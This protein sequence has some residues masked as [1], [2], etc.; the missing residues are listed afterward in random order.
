M[1]ITSEHFIDD[2]D[3]N[4]ENIPSLQDDEVCNSKPNHD[5]RLLGP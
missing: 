4:D 5:G 2:D 1:Q 3:D